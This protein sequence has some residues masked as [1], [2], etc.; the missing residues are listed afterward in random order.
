MWCIAALRSDGEDCASRDDAIEGFMSVMS[1]LSAAYQRIREIFQPA[2][3]G[4]I[5]PDPRAKKRL[6][7]LLDAPLFADEKL[8]GDFFDAV[9]R[10][11]FEVQSREVGSSTEAARRRLT[12]AET[13]GGVQIGIP[14]IGN[15]NITAKGKHEWERGGKQMESRKLTEVAVNSVGRRLEEIATVYVSTYPERVAFLDSDGTITTFDGRELSVE[16]VE[17]LADE[18]PRML[19]FIELAPKTPIMPMACEL[20]SGRVMLLYERYIEEV[21]PQDGEAAPEYPSD[22]NSTPETRLAYWRA[23]TKAFRS[24]AAMEVV[25]SAGDPDKENR[26]DKLAWIDFRVP[27][28]GAHTLHLH[29]VPDGK[30]HT[31]VFGYNLVR[32]GFRQGVRIVGTLKAGLDVNALAIFDR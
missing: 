22:A 19:V 31:G 25:E 17:R 26:S 1:S 27:V 15:T 14:F 12:S 13:T 5:Y 23:L 8:I 24:R 18:P 7:W 4:H 2:N 6:Q 20:L 3:T 32:R 29:C 10:P 28:G 21:F 11:E 30:A 9:V 16:E